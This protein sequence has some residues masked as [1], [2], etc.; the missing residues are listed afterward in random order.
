[1]LEH[2]TEL[3]KVPDNLVVTLNPTEITIS[4]SQKRY[5]KDMGDL[6]ELA[7]S[8]REMGQIQPIVITRDT[9]TLVAGGRRLAA[10]LLYDLQVKAIYSDTI[11]PI[12]LREIE[13]EEN[14]KRKQF[15]PAEE[16]LAVQEIHNMKQAQFGVSCSGKPGVGWS[17]TDTAKLLGKSHVSVMADIKLA[18]MVNQYPEL[19]NA[20]KKNA[21][22]KIATGMERL[23]ATIGRMAEHEDHAA[24][25]PDENRLWAVSQQDARDF[26]SA[27]PDSS[28][29]VLLTDPPYGIDISV[30]ALNASNTT[31][32]ASASGFSFADDSEKALSLYA[33]LAIESFRFTTTDAHGFIFVAPEFFWELRATFIAAG[34]QAHIKPL[35]WIK[36]SSGQCNAPHAWPSSCYEMI[37]YVRKQASQ[38]IQEGKA[39]WL[40]CGIVDVKLHPTEK[41]I[42]LLKALLERVALPYQTLVD[43]FMGSGSSILAGVQMKLKSSG[44]DELTESYA[45]ALDRLVKNDRVMVG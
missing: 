23:A 1:M 28:V 27:I 30:T 41:P 34:W 10:C 9:N 17:L 35:I 44:C 14:I 37:L 5:R 25:N 21:I 8:I 40:E 45:I 7:S 22:A 4:A 42:A 15:T 24:N 18:E 20:K 19:I 32:G 29:N 12:K 33:A 43:P 26:M 38:F 13:L 16:V 6:K 31:G 11:D 36:R 2:V 3:D 39:D